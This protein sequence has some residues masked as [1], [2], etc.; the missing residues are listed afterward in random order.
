MRI[1]IFAYYLA[2]DDPKKCTSKKLAKYGILRI[3]KRARQIP[4]KAIVLNPLAKEV[5]SKEDT[6]LV[7]AHGLVV[8]DSSWKKGYEIFGKIRRGEQRRLPTLIAANPVNYGKPFELSSAEALATAL[9]CLGFHEEA[10]TILNKFKWGVEF[11]KLNAEF[12]SSYTDVNL[13]LTKLQ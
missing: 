13:L 7:S 6:T 5:L 9:L 4:K 1:K 3:I 8:I 11:V 12:F 10:V 2:Q